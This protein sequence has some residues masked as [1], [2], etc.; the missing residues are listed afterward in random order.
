MGHASK[1]FW[2]RVSNNRVWAG[3]EGDRASDAEGETTS[4]SDGER[5]GGD[6]D[7]TRVDAALLAGDRPRA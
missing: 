4:D 6:I 7:S 1:G 2:K 3:Q 5:S